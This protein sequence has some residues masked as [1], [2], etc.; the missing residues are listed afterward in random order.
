MCGGYISFSGAP[1]HLLVT[2]FFLQN[3]ACGT[4]NVF[5]A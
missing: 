4:K 5:P 1:A 3:R 2:I